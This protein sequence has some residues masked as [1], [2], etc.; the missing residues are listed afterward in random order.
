MSNDTVF[1]ITTTLIVFSLGILANYIIKKCEKR[2]SKRETRQFV[3]YHL[4]KIIDSFSTKLNT[5]YSDVSKNTTI[6]SG[7][8]LTPPKLLSND[9]QRILHLESKE[10][11][12]SVINKN[13]LSNIVSQVD[14]LNNLI[15]E[16]Q[17]YH[18]LALKDSNDLRKRFNERLNQYL[19]SLDDFLEYE[20]ENTKH[21]DKT[22]PYKTINDSIIKFYKEVSGKRELKKFHDEILIPN[23]EYLVSSDLYRIHPNAKEIAKIGKDLSLIFND[24]D[25]LTSEFKEQYKEFADLIVISIES[26]NNNIIKIKWC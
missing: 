7:I 18:N 13:E 2:K 11:F 10:L 1:T 6:D 20:R 12:N 19:D 21:Y 23:Q 9:F 8:T 17:V 15:S 16:V 26:M 14:F 25:G 24:L 5:A 4:D 3:K 22:L